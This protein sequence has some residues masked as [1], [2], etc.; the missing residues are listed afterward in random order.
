MAD[1]DRPNL[2]VPAIS[3]DEMLAT[4]GFYDVTSLEMHA[5]GRYLQ[6]EV[7]ASGVCHQLTPT[8]QRDGVLARDGWG[9]TV[10][11]IGRVAGP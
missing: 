3:L 10:F 5:C 6:V 2:P 9:P 7:D 8:G 1:H 4:P 11:V